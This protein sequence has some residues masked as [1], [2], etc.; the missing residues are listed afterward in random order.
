MPLRGIIFDLDG[1][2]VDSQL[3][4]D[5]MRREMGLPERQPILEGLNLIPPGPHKDHCLEVLSRHERR[6]A[7]C[8][9]LMPYV[10]EFL[11][12]LDRRAI[13]QAILTRNSRHSTEHVLDRLGLSFAPVATRE[14]HPPKPDPT[15]LLHICEVWQFAPDDILFFGDYLFDLEAGRNAGISTVLYAPAE[16]PD[17]AAQATFTIRCYSEAIPLID[18]L[19][20]S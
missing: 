7:E 5:A 18:R 3:D 2:L 4:F 15:G 17:Y 9:T 6:G 19:I 20:A 10:R 8:A 12:E 13:P 14:D 11:A 1:T 16:I